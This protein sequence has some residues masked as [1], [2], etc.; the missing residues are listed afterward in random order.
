[1]LP[2]PTVA[3]LTLLEPVVATVLA[4]AV[5]DESVTALQVAGGLLLLTALAVLGREAASSSRQ[6]A[7]AR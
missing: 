7:G 1:V 4:V 6:P 3:T 2:A 5:L